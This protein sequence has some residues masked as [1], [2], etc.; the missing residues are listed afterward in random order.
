ML[1]TLNFKR[2]ILKIEATHGGVGRYG[3]KAFF[4]PRTKQLQG[5]V[6]VHF[7][8]VE[9]R[10]R[11][12]RCQVALID[13]HRVV[14]S[15]GDGTELGNVFIEFDVHQAVFGQCVHGDG[16]GPARLQP[17]QRL[18]HGHLV[19]NGLRLG[20]RGL[21][22]PVPGLDDACLRRFFSGFHTCGSR[23]KAPD[24]YRIGGVVRTLVNHLEHVLAADDAGRD[25][26]TAGSP[27]VG[28]R[29]L[30][31]AKWHLVAGYGYGLEQ[32]A[33][34]HF[35]GSLVEKTEV[36]VGVHHAAFCNAASA[37]WA[38]SVLLSDPGG[39]ACLSCAWTARNL[40]TSSSSD[41][42]ST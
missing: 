13:Q 31:R 12:G 18:W 34:Y 25:L 8:V 6:H 39:P 16:L 33:A 36:V 10:Y 28:K 19:N 24:V 2:M 41:W 35:F 7:R 1:P 21:R 26:H 30:A 22:D 9:F 40:R 37:A 5:R 15:L 3:V 38:A 11:R 20:Q 27:A 17:E 42:K 32:G 4:T 23:K 14:V 29:H